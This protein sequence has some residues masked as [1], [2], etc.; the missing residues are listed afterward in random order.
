MGNAC[1]YADN[2]EPRLTPD[3]LSASS[4]YLDSPTTSTS[5]REASYNFRRGSPTH[6]TTR[7][8]RRKSWERNTTPRV[9][10]ACRAPRGTPHEKGKGDGSSFLFSALFESTGDLVAMDRTER[11]E[12]ESLN[13]IPDPGTTC[14]YSEEK[15][16]PQPPPTEAAQHWCSLFAEKGSEEGVPICPPMNLLLVEKEDNCR[17][18]VADMLRFTGHKV[19][20]ARYGEHVLSLMCEPHWDGLLLGGP[21]CDGYGWDLIKNYRL[22]EQHH[23][24]TGSSGAI[25]LLI[26]TADKAAQGVATR[27]KCSS[28]EKP[29]TVSSLMHACA[30]FHGSKRRLDS[31]ST[32]LSPHRPKRPSEQQ[33]FLT[34]QP[35]KLA[36][37]AK[38][39]GR[40][41]ERATN[42]YHEKSSD[43]AN[44]P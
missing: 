42:K 29:V 24:K 36:A 44:L 15:H 20:Y 38:I 13:A 37:A 2:D 26:P 34:S 28:L 43:N 33:I 32:S 7:A 23:N 5:V 14:K 11:V 27:W 31:P 35:P 25:C 22:W 10:P 3:T 30:E 40:N 41:S 8:K 18:E 4:L 17:K 1:R 19:T 21:K 9:F 6:D 12:R 39:V 16:A